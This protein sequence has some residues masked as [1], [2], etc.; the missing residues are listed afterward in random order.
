MN[1]KYM[2]E[3]KECHSASDRAYE[4]F[5]QSE[6]IMDEKNIATLFCPRCNTKLKCKGYRTVS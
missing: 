4:L 1:I 5:L 2:C 3:N 6:S